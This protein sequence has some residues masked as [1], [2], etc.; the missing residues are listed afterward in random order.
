MLGVASAPF[1]CID[2]GRRVCLIE[3]GAFE[4]AWVTGAQT[5][6][7]GSSLER[8]PLLHS[9]ITWSRTGEDQLE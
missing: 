4:E 3:P 8:E 5:L 7:T 1:L 9:S 2:L 6:K